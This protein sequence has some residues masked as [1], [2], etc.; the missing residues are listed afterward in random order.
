MF[1]QPLSA[2]PDLK[3]DTVRLSFDIGPSPI[4]MYVRGAVAWPVGKTPGMALVAGFD[5]KTEHIWIFDDYVFLTYY[6]L[7]AKNKGWEVG[8]Q[9][10]LRDIWIQYGCNA[11]FYASDPETHQLFSRQV[12]RDEILK[13]LNISFIKVPY[14]DDKIA[15]N[16]IFSRT[17]LKTIHWSAQSDLEQQ[18]ADEN[19]RGRHALRTLVAGFEYLPWHDWTKEE[20][21]KE[22]FL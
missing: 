21:I 16:N 17:D 22:Y 8:L 12:Y 3:R 6:P 18:R 14:T 4:D 10:F 11:L 1:P 2:T 5:I 15:D 20:K 7:F 13:P 9:L 19:S